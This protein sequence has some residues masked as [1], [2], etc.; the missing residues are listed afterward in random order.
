MEQNY[1]YVIYFFRKADINIFANAYNL[2]YAQ[3]ALSLYIICYKTRC[4][5]S[6]LKYS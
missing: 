1:A 3:I 2:V 4:F 6:M 5:C